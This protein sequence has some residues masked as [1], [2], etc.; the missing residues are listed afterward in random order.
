MKR[1]L[2]IIIA[3]IFLASCVQKK[4][5]GVFDEKKMTDVLFDLH[6]ADGFNATYYSATVDDP[7]IDYYASVY[8]KYNTDSAGVRA[9]LTYYA[10]LPQTLQDIYAEVS[11]RLQRVDAEYKKIQMEKERVAFVADSIAAKRRTDSVHLKMRDSLIHFNGPHDLFLPDTLKKDTLKKNA[12]K[13]DSLKHQ[14]KLIPSLSKALLNEQKHWEMIFYYFKES[15]FFPL[16]I[17]PSDKV[18]TVADEKS[19]KPKTEVPRLN[20]H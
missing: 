10:A 12:S 20:E 17:A 18:K 15:T 14:G 5:E 19:V 8:E 6:L 13:I 4:P 16:F 2:G 9:N 11:K 1:F 7:G 3:I